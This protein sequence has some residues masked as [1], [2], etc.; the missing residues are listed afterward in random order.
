MRAILIGV[1]TVAAFA[2]IEGA[3]HT[4]R[5]FRERKQDELKRRLQTL[6][7]GITTTTSLLRKGNLSG[8]PAVDAFLRTFSFSSKAELLLEQAE[9]AMTVAKLFTSSGMGFVVGGVLG[10]LSNMGVLLSFALAP[11]GAAVPFMYVMFM[12]DRRN[13]KLS[14]QLPAGGGRDALA[15]QHRVRAGLR[16]AEPGHAVR[17]RRR[18]DDEAGP[19][20]PRSE[21]LRRVRHR[22][23]GDGRQPGRDHREDRGDH[24]RPLPLLRQAAHA[25]RRG[26]HVQLHPGRAAHPDGDLHRLHEPGVHAPAGHRPDRPRRRRLRR[27][28]L[29]GGA[30]VDAP[31]DEGGRL[32]MGALEGMHWELGVAAGA[33]LLFVVALA[34]ALRSLLSRGRD[35]L[36]AR[37]ERTEA[38]GSTGTVRAAVEDAP[39]NHS[40]SQALARFF[41]PVAWLARPGQA[42]ELAKLRASLIRA[43]YR[44]EHSMEI[45]LGV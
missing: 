4:V 34:A 35:E 16:G 11:L 18:A 29:A 6:G 44:G 40:T 39:E 9:V 38:A 20:Q 45:F 14:E 21:D 24:P 42:E 1:L 3:F 15:H 19:Q 10:L 23:E 37:I 5:Y 31:H 28:D 33:G 8:T 30:A 26:P 25:D 2:L 7:S 36:V 27:R 32:A 22:A 17:A 13:N 12:R 41:R 43:G